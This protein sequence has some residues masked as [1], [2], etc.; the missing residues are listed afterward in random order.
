M[1]PLPWPDVCHRAGLL[2]GAA[3]LLADGA[4]LPWTRG[5]FGF[6]ALP[7]AALLV[8][9]PSLGWRRL[10]D[11]RDPRRAALIVG[12]IIPVWIV[13]AAAVSP[14]LGATLVPDGVEKPAAGLLDATGWIPFAGMATRLAGALVS[15]AH[16]FVLLLAVWLAW[17]PRGVV[18]PLLAI[19]LPLALLILYHPGIETLLGLLFL[20]WFFGMSREVALMLPPHIERVLDER[21]AAFLAHVAR[22]GGVRVA[23]VPLMLPGGLARCAELEALGLV[24]G[25]GESGTVRAGDALA[26]SGGA[27]SRTAGWLGRAA[28]IAV[29]SLYLLF[30]DLLPGPIDDLVVMLLCSYA[31]FRLPGRGG[32]STERA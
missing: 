19:G 11:W 3:L 6:A 32:L 16:L 9:M 17:R 2:L 10:G 7:I 30:P 4:G 18:A 23:E 15:L 29:G 1:R 31:G 24:Q 22:N 12:A 5:L 13:V 27:G 28:W 20:A 26:K 25:D 8:G 21:D 14:E